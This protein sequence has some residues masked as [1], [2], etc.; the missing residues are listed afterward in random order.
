L[1]LEMTFWY[2][3]VEKTQC[4]DACLQVD[5][6]VWQWDVEDVQ[7][8]YPRY[9]WMLVKPK[10]AEDERVDIS[11]HLRNPPGGTSQPGAPKRK[12]LAPGWTYFAARWMLR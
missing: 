5:G 9:S 11:L 10:P 3:Q 7:K 2:S 12:R 1:R 6:Q 4:V 8:E